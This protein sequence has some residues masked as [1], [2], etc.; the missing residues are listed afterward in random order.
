MTSRKPQR[1]D[2][3]DEQSDRVVRRRFWRRW[4]ICSA[5]GVGACMAVSPSWRTSS[6]TSSSTSSD[7]SV[8]AAASQVEQITAADW[9]AALRTPAG[10][11]AARIVLDVRDQA[12]DPAPGRLPASVV[13]L[14]GPAGVEVGALDVSTT[15]RRFPSL[16]GIPGVPSWPSLDGVGLAAVAV[17]VGL[18]AVTRFF[19]FR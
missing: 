5:V 11:A 10:Q 14:S 19:R 6:S 8:E 3:V 17:L 18:V 9:V 2:P 7:S 12:A 4:L 16:P 1:R 13:G 15:V